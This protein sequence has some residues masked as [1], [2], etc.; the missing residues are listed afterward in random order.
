MPKILSIDDSRKV[1][2]FIARGFEG[3]EVN[4]LFVS[5]GFPGPT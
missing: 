5:N 1:H 3:Y 2:A 4:L